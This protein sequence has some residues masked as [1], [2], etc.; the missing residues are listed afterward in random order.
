MKPI[1]LART[2]Y[3]IN[4]SLT[5]EGVR[6]SLS[7]LKQNLKEIQI[8]EY[9]CG[10]RCFD[11]QIPPEWNIKEGWI[12]TLDGEKIIDLKENNLHVMGYSAPINKR[13]SREELLKH[14]HTSKE[15]VHAI[16]Y[17]TSYYKKDW[18]F[19]MSEN[20]RKKLIKNIYEV[21]IDS[22]FN[23]QGK[24]NYGEAVIKGETEKEVLI[25][26]YICH[27][28]MANNE[29]SGPVVATCIGR[30]LNTLKKRKY[31]YRLLFLPE[32]IGSIAY[33]SKNLKRMKRN[34]KAG[35]VL[36]C[37]G[38]EKNY[39]YLQSRSGNTLSDRAAKLALQTIDKEYKKYGWNERGSDERQYCAPGVDLPI[40]SIMRT[41]YNEYPEYHTSLDNFDVVTEKGLQGGINAVKQTLIIIER[42]INPKCK[43]ICE[44]QLGKRGLYPTKSDKENYSRVQ[45]MLNIISYCDGEHD[46]IDIANKCDIPYI[47]IMEYI[48]R[49]REEG[50]IKANKH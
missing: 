15:N 4:R 5:G 31:T 44:P 37:I 48:D 10:D 25:S 47:K 7:I 14:I 33:I 50:I 3:P 23:A 35:F 21:C 41:K 45:D 16:P 11:W 22:S 49:L 39:S 30:W 17:I 24:L 36:T 20:Q 9:K 34:T 18:A 29:I 26:T 42:N 27:P 2:L 6:M 43:I 46:I 13:I 38:D 12:K 32:T 19:C 8:K 1:E 40:C 28:S